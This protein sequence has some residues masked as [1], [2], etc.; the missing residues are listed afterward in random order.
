M[1][2]VYLLT[3]TLLILSGCG[4][5]ASN[6]ATN[7]SAE[8]RGAPT[9]AA[10]VSP[11]VSAQTVSIDSPDGV[12]LAGTYFDSG[13]PNSPGLLLLHQWQSDRHSFDEFAKRMQGRGFA[14][15]SVDGRG[16]GESVKAADGRTI[17]PDRS[18]AA[19]KAMLDDVHA[20]IEFLAKQKNVDPARIGIVGASYGSSLALIYAAGNQ[21]I[22]AAALLSPGLNYFG[23]M[24]TM[25]AI[26][27]YGNR[28][29]FMAAADDDKE[30]ADAVAQLFVEGD[31]AAYSAK[32]YGKGG[33]GTDMLQNSIGAEADVEKFLVSSLVK[34]GGKN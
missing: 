14:V 2:T 33:H 3:I 6:Q 20:A 17:E 30:S 13:Q 15:L 24:Q 28:P 7:K 9:N 34:D 11:A 10:P 22:A 29:L 1:R 4:G 31:N 16:F 19:V 26:K 27:K 21:K 25:P 8:N 32:V 12:K 18:S 23:N 5:D